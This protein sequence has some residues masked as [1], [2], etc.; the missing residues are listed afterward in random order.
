MAVRPVVVCGLIVQVLKHALQLAVFP[1]SDYDGSLSLLDNQVVLPNEQ[2]G[3]LC[4]IL[5][6]VIKQF[7]GQAT[8]A[9]AD[10]SLLKGNKAKFSLEGDGAVIHPIFGDFDLNADKEG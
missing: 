2:I 6:P 8:L 3:F 7:P 1:G 4:G 9:I 5:H 10:F